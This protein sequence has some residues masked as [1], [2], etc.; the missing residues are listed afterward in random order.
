MANNDAVKNWRK[1]LKERALKLFGGRCVCCGYNTC[2]AALE[3]HH[4]EPAHKDFTLSSVYKNPKS[5]DAIVKELE[6][7]ALVCANCHREIHYG[8]RSIEYKC[9]LDKTL[10]DYR[11]YETDK[12][13]K[14][15]CGITIIKTK[16][17]CSP[18]CCARDRQTIKWE[19]ERDSIL[20]L[21]D[22][23]NLS[24]IQI[25]HKYNTSDNTIRKWYLRFKNSE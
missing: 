10:I 14:C 20:H 13:K 5:W 1:N 2:S 19:Q 12:Y 24:Y 23:L 15:I 7:C 18:E 11:L 6:K 9:Y 4:L 17:Y 22:D 25:A 21:K 8:S 3:F 16:K